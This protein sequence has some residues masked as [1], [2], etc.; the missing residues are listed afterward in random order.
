M[1]MLGKRMRSVNIA[2]LKN[3]L[4]T[5]VGYAKNGEE[6]VVRER[7]VAVAKLVPMEPGD[8]TEDE[9]WLVAHGKMTLP[10]KKLTPRALE[11][12]LSMPVPKPRG[13][14]GSELLREEREEG[15]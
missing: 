4:S 12:F 6:V 8:A 14:T 5:Y 1:A 11:E 7:K 2:E 13:K 3:R 15:R 9:R 10:K